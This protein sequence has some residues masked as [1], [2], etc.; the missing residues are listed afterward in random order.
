MA[1]KS[2]RATL[3]AIALSLIGSGPSFAG[4]LEQCATACRAYEAE[5]DRAQDFC[6]RLC[7][8]CYNDADEMACGEAHDFMR[9]YKDS[10][11]DPKNGAKQ[12]PSSGS[13]AA[14]D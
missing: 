1:R 3:A 9:R 13:G 8:A 12:G 6:S 10:K 4:D 11:K 2:L 14:S 7:L 5:A